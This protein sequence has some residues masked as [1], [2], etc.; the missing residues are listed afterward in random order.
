MEKKE[1]ALS[2]STFVWATWRILN[3]CNTWAVLSFDFCSNP[4]HR[5][6][7]YSIRACWS[8]ECC[9]GLITP[10]VTLL[11]RRYENQCTHSTSKSYVWKYYN[12]GH[13]TCHI[14][15]LNSVTVLTVMASSSISTASALLSIYVNVYMHV[16]NV[17][18]YFLR[19][20]SSGIN[21]VFQLLVSK[22]RRNLL[23]L[24]SRL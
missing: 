1:T 18:L 17:S 23:L 24:S 9:G 13:G 22:F 12:R 14:I 20:Q 7:S 2:W 19:S 21:R 10:D 11:R 15:A 5:L 16:F 6:F 8:Y 3:I 4:S